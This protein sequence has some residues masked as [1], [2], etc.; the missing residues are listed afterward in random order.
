MK[1]RSFYKN[2]ITFIVI[3]FVFG[4]LLAL[5]RWLHRDDLQ[6]A[7]GA[8]PMCSFAYTN[9]Y[10][11]DQWFYNDVKKFHNGSIWYYIKH[12]Y[13]Y[14]NDSLFLSLLFCQKEESVK[15]WSWEIVE[16]HQDSKNSSIV[17]WSE[18]LEGVGKLSITDNTL[19]YAGIFSIS[20]PSWF[21][22]VE[23]TDIGGMVQMK[24]WK[25][26]N[27]LMTIYSPTLAEKF[28]YC[29]MIAD[30]NYPAD[31]KIL[32][33]TFT[34][35]NIEVR[36]YTKQ[37]NDDTFYTP[38]LTQVCFVKGKLWYKIRIYDDGWYK[39]D[40]INSIEFL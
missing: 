34:K 36:T 17:T 1:K 8:D 10:Y 3:I 9:E 31:A 5:I 16:S 18:E 30:Q 4:F 13:L 27:Q 12:T 11:P 35:D 21:Q 29:D 14:Y 32:K 28:D 6:F 2:I 23:I 37:A 25:D 22:T 20:L 40:I 24:D 19:N 26:T 39:K 33:E 38:F 7:I 15:I